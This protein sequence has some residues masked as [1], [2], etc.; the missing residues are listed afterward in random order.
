MDLD[1]HFITLFD[2]VKIKLGLLYN[3]TRLA[4]IIPNKPSLI[5]S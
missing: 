4:A 3:S 1:E 2:L 5:F